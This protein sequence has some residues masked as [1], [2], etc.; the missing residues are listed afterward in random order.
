MD[1]ESIKELLISTNSKFKEL[2]EQ[3]RELDTKVK[4]MYEKGFL[5]P[6]EEVEMKK[7]KIRKLRLKEQIERMIVEA[8]ES[9]V[10]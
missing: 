9:T 1:R 4:K 2:V 8:M 6:E 3:H 10:K 5:T 7:M